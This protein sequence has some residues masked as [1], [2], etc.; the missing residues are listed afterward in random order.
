MRVISGSAKGIQ[1]VSVPGKSTR[2]I[3]DRVKEALFNI[4]SESVYDTTWLDLFG[5]TGAVGI[6][7]LSRGAEHVLFIELNFRAC[8]VI[9][10]NLKATKLSEYASVQK[11]DAFTLL[12]ADP[13]TAFDVIYVAP[14]QYQ[15]MWIKAMQALDEKPTWLADG[16]QII[17]QIHPKE[18]DDSIGYANLIEFDRRQYGDTLLIFYEHSLPE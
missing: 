12:N 13:D 7:A 2:P 18:W 17:I 6:E 3:T 15:G 4:L 14:P 8:K 5:G 1:L 11:M 9:H 10:E 16:G